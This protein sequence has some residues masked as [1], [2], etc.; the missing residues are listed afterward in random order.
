MK[1]QTFGFNRFRKGIVRNRDGFTLIEIL[2]VVA[3]IALLVAIL[4]PSLAAAREQAYVVV[5][6]QRM[7]QLYRGHAFYG[8]DTKANRFPMWSWW[9]YDGKGHDK[10][11]EEIL[12]AAAAYNISGG[13]R[14]P[15]EQSNRWVEYGDIYRYIKEKEVYFCPRDDKQRT[16]KSLGGG[17][18]GQGKKPIHSYVRLRD[19]HRYNQNTKWDS[20]KVGPADFLSPDN[21]KPRCLKH[22]TWPIETFFTVPSRVVLL[23]E[24]YQGFGDSLLGTN[25]LALNDG[26]SDM[27]ENLGATSDPLSPRH[28]KRGS[29]IYWDGHADLA[30][31]LKWRKDG[32]YAIRKALGGSMGQ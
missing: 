12:G 3:I 29:I 15:D 28:R 27:I 1:Q 22:S 18:P 24:E 11:K 8:A 4:L 6:K 20:S 25:T 9:L 10:S 23:F 13:V 14:W 30:D 31:A 5:C 19:A 2:V 21:L 32:N 7:G 16:A 17:Q 26:H